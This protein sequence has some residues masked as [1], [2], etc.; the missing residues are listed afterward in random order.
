MADRNTTGA[1]H[2]TSLDLDIS[3]V[4]KSL[5]E[6]K[7]SVETTAQ[8]VRESFA[9]A[10]KDLTLNEIDTS[11]I[12]SSF[13]S[14]NNISKGITVTK[15]AI[16]SLNLSYKTFLNTLSKSKLQDNLISDI[17]KNAK[18][19]AKEMK[20]LTSSIQEGV[21][22]TKEHSEQYKQLQ[23]TLKTLKGELKDIET[24]A[25]Q[26]GTGF[27]NLGN[28]AQE[29]DNKV[30]GLLLRLGEK[31]KWMVAYQ[32]VNLVQQALGN[33]VNTIKDTEDAAIELQRVLNNP[34]DT[35]A[36]S[37][38]LYDI[39]YR[40]GQSFQNVQ[41][42][43]VL[44]A[45]TGQDW[46]DVLASVEATMLGLN[47][48]ELEVTTATNGLI[49]VMS[50]FHIEAT[51]L[52]EVIDKI[53]IT[54]DN[55]PVTSEKIVAALQ[56]AGGT[57]YNFGLT[58]EET[59]GIITALSEATGRS[60]EN[61]GTALNSLISFS[62]K[63]ESLEKFSEYLGGIDLSD[64]NVLEVWELLGSKIDDSGESLARMMASSEEFAD[65][66][67]EELATAVGLTEE[68]NAAVMNSQDVY[69]TVGTY[70]QNYFIAL[71]NNIGTATEAIQ[72]MTDAE[73]Y[74]IAENEKAMEALSKQ[75]NQFVSTAQ[76]LA[77]QFGNA[78]FLDILKFITSAST[79]VLQL[80][81]N[82]GG[83]NT[84]IAILGTLLFKVK[85][86]KIVD[87]LVKIPSHIKNILSVF[88]GLVTQ[89]NIVKV[90]QD[91]YNKSLE[92]QEAAAIKAGVAYD[93]MKA[94]STAAATA[95]AT[96]I[97]SVISILS[98]VTTV[99]FTAVNAW[100]SYKESIRQARQET[101][102]TGIAAGETSNS[103]YELYKSYLV[104]QQSYDDTTEASEAL[105]EAS[106]NLKK[107]LQD[108]GIDVSSLSGD[109][110]EL[111]TQMKEL[112]QIELEQILLKQSEAVVAA[113]ASIEDLFTGLFGIKTAIRSVQDDWYSPGRVKPLYIDYKDIEQFL[114]VYDGLIERQKEIVDSMG[115]VNA[116]DDYNYK[117]INELVKKYEPYVSA[118]REAIDAQE[119]TL[120]KIE[121]IKK[122]TVD[123]SDAVDNL[124]SSFENN[125]F[126]II[127]FGTKI[128]NLTNLFDE[129]SNKVDSFQNA[130]SSVVDIVNEYNETGIMTADMLQKLLEMEPEYISIL[131]VKTNSL[132]LNENA[133]NDLIN[134]NDEHLQQLVAI[135]IAE[136]AETFATE[137]QTAAIQNKT[138]AEIESANA[139]MLLS[140][141]LANAILGE[142]QGTNAS[143]ELATALGNVAQSASLSGDYLSY[144]TGKINDM[145]SSYSSLLKTIKSDSIKTY[146]TPKVSTGGNGGTSP[147]KEAIQNE[148]K[149]LKKQK[150]IS[151]QYYKDLEDNLKQQK[152]DSD[153]YY[154]NL[155][156]NLKKVEEENSRIND[157]LDY[158]SDRQK[159]L[160][161]IEQAKSRS[162][163]E[164]RQK[165]MEYQQELVDIDED[166]RRKQEEWSI[167]DQIEAFEKLKEQ[168][169]KL[170]EEQIDELKNLKDAAISELEDAINQLQEKVNALSKSTASTIS[171]G[172]NAGLDYGETL[173]EHNIEAIDE[174]NLK[175]LSN[176]EKRTHQ[177]IE[178]MTFSF[179]GLFES[180][181]LKAKTEFF[182]ALDSIK[183]H[184][185]NTAKSA[186][187][188]ID[189]AVG[190]TLKSI[191][192]HT[193]NTAKSAANSVKLT[194]N[195]GLDEAL[196]KSSNKI[197]TELQQ[198]AIK[199]ANT[200][201]KAYEANLI[202][203]LR[204]QIKGALSGLDLSLSKSTMGV[205]KDFPSSNSTNNTVNMYNNISTNSAANSAIRGVMNFFN[206]DPRS[207]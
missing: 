55:F 26:T 40:Y 3:G 68:Y 170:I 103:I 126:N 17:A 18:E 150:E 57:A 171:N 135:K 204:D 123:L 78:G 31:A 59:I 137:L 64:K 116:A 186:L 124:S 161:N 80:L 101:I 113:K 189:L 74:S 182:S 62:M 131:D 120:K 87:R 14:T 51:D 95:A 16:E 118:L 56:R 19:S 98:V 81:K 52:E 1:V 92:D 166:W 148:I 188:G 73:G 184:S 85:Q 110:G 29:S 43:A 152:E 106:N 108:E 79:G 48:A 32:I 65:L 102:D 191:K 22:V 91:A 200:M 100:N 141:E 194:L 185:D 10:T 58:L 154:D 46:E 24:N 44:F 195:K 130:Y 75:W 7:E 159:K 84:V 53:N 9:N 129:L 88:K 162:G 5:N 176:I 117:I 89:I 153:N 107:A 206:T 90:V 203:P 54:A 140:S 96:A 202:K 175:N 160:T 12:V 205:S 94:K 104:A 112:M 63:A 105:T 86:Q 128:E 109:Y 167:D 165:E 15:S 149:A 168:A 169:A 77:V 121:D 119:E 197:N 38:A 181:S 127:D 37:D 190:D 144:F 151:T 20:K 71:L 164:W 199:S 132:S 93:V 8:Q 47:T 82:I 178:D 142:I 198:A 143:N 33:V 207:F 23:S 183:T 163:I 180:S 50:Q 114:K 30:A 136:E 76:E 67:N 111:A 13:N 139:T 196:I 41:E 61:I 156:N 2:L 66:F 177:A 145:I 42:T 70:R 97:T 25:I 172:I 6:I 134:K 187:N 122:G 83:L 39:A 21:P 173:L 147:Q 4:Q 192:T 201:R 49:A 99:I 60:G 35:K 34:P 28:A 115:A 36:I 69:S 157:Q 45:Q 125:E 179:D 27:K 133:V 155:I 11:K 193:E 72:G 146:Y 138:I 174:A 158:Y